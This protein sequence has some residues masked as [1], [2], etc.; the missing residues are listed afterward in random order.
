[1][2]LMQEDKM[3]SWVGS[4]IEKGIL[5][6]QGVK[7]GTEYLLNPEL[8]AQA[9]LDLRPSLKTIE[10]YKLEALII[11]DLRYNGKSKMKQIVSRLSEIPFQEVSKAVYRMAKNEIIEKEGADKTMVYFYVQKKAK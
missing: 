6:S 11:E 7:K 10:P 8:F 1:M 2:I 4:L 5:I 3:R 9:K